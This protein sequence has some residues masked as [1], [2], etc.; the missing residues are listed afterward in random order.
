MVKHVVLID[1][2]SAGAQT[3]GDSDRRV[4]VVGVDSRREAISAGV[5]RLENLLFRFE[6]GDGADGA[7]DLFLH[8]LHVFRDVGE[9]GRLDEISLI[10]MA[11]T[12]SDDGGTLLLPLFNVAHDTVILELGDLWALEGV[13]CEWVAD[14][15]CKSASLESLDELVVDTRLNVNTRAGTAALAMVEEDTKVDPRD[16][17]LDIGIVENNVG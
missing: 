10:T 7:E 2:D 14:L 4:E 13:G 8:D 12:T 15:V 16:S 11:L 17:V 1:P 9:D 5:C 3:I 6:L